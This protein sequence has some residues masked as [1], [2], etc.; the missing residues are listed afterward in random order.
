MPSRAERLLE[1]LQVLRGRRAPV[2]ASGLA[3]TL[4]VSL[5]TLY[6]DIQSLRVQGADIQGEAGV[7]YLLRPGFTLPPLMFSPE[8]LDALALGA[9]WV[10]QNGDAAL[11]E[12]AERAMVKIAAVAPRDAG[13]FIEAPTQLVREKRGEARQDDWMPK[14]REAMRQERKVAL[15]YVDAQGA[16]TQRMIWPIALGFMTEH[17]VVAAWCEA[18]VAFRHFRVDRI[19]SLA[20]TPARY[21]R[22][23]RALLAE[24]RKAEGLEG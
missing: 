15:D 11:A 20:I 19:A 17:R 3:E 1:L 9:R 13:E 16:P 12:A 22:R 2:A 6:R 18:R 14:L 24:W 5:R 4:G 8:E 7:G 23:R 21:P 10:R